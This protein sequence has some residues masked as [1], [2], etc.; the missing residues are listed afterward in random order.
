MFPVRKENK[1]RSSP[2]KGRLFFLYPSSASFGWA[3]SRQKPS[4]I[5]AHEAQSR[6]GRVQERSSYPQLGCI[7]ASALLR[8]PHTLRQFPQPRGALL[9]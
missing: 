3:P 7:L 8:P 1:R 9:V 6:G 2:D 5:I 4:L